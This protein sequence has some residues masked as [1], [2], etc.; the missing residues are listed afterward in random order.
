[1]TALLDEIE[2]EWEVD[3]K[4][5]YND[6]GNAAVNTGQLHSKYLK[7]LN[8]AKKLL[9]KKQA[10]YEKMFHLKKEYYGGYLSREQIEARQWDYNPLKGRAK[11][12]KGEMEGFVKIDDE[13]MQL[14]QEVEELTQLK[15]TLIDIVEMIRFRNNSIRVAVDWKMFEAGA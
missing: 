5:N 14:K 1:M 9:R 4:I 15:E 11:P 10:A 12:L 8:I 3:S 13:V 2:R 7:Y 6:L